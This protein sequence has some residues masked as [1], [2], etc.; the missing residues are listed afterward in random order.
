MRLQIEHITTFS[1]DSLISEAY[2]EMRLAP[3]DLGGQR[4]AMFRLHTD[5]EGDVIRYLDRYANEVHYFD[6]LQPHQQL[7]VTAISQVITSEQFQD[8]KRSLSPLE[9]HDYLTATAYTSVDESLQ[10]LAGQA[11]EAETVS[12]AV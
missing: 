10:A 2:T 6:V 5:P 9:K 8:E 7:R 3:H 1:Y 4:R 11:M 12:D